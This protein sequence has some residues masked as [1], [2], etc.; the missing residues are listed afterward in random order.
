[1]NQ[2]VY[3]ALYHPEM[4]LLHLGYKEFFKHHP[5]LCEGTYREMI[6]PKYEVSQSF[7]KVLFK[8]DFDIKS[9]AGDPGDL[10]LEYKA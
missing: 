7:K 8:I 1:M 6:D 5:D 10:C 4:Y 9:T 2:N 3:P